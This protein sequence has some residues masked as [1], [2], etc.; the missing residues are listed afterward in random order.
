MGYYT[1]HRIKIYSEGMKPILLKD[2][3]NHK[4]RIGKITGYLYD[5][6]DCQIKWYKCNDQMKEYSKEYPN[7]IF[8]ITGY[9]EE[10]QDIWRTY[11]KNGKSQ[12]ERAIVSFAEFNP[13]LLCE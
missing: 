11:Y 5:T 4:R 3:N 9:G 8:E 7:L 1:D 10:V 13:L 2:L 12:N 6:F